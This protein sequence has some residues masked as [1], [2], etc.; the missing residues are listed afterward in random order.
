M[1][2]LE[3]EMEISAR[4]RERTTPVFDGTG[5]ESR[6]DAFVRTRVRQMAIALCILAALRILVFAAAFP[7]TNNTDEKLHFLT[8]R[9]YAQGQMPGKD[10]PPIDPEFARALLLYQSPEY[11]LSQEYLDRNGIVGPPYNLPPQAR[12]AVLANKFYSEKL[13]RWLHYGFNYE[14]QSAPFYYVVAGCWYRLGASL[15]F[16]DWGLAY[17]VRFLNPIA[18]ALVLWFSYC[19]VRRVYPERTFLQVAVPAIIAVF[20]QDVF[21]GMNRDVISPVL[22]AAALLCLIRAVDAKPSRYGFLLAGS[23]LAGLGFLSDIPNCVLFGALAATLWI[24]IERSTESRGRKVW[25]VSTSALAAGVLPCLWILRNYIVMGDLLGGKAKE[26]NLG[27][28]IKPFS[29]MVNHPLFS[30]VGSR[31]FLLQLTSRF[32]H[33]E[34]VWH[35]SPMKSAL[36]DRFYVVSSFVFVVVFLVDLVIRRKSIPT[37]QKLAGAQAL[38]LVITSVGF[39]ALIS[40]P[41][42][43]NYC[44]Y[45]SREYPYFVSGRIISGALLPFVL[46]YASGLELV[47]NLVRRWVSPFALRIMPYAL[48]SCLVVFITISEVHVRSGVFASPYNFFALWRR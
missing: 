48:L 21:F 30:F 14:A 9:M 43:F 12:D 28:T 34:Y 32:W 10:L 36:A 3:Q 42:D 16:R 38:F 8:I 35:N 27:W 19:F 46:M 23:L 44:A 15:G 13:T 17:W 22:A 47:T 11:G 25:V 33:G 2:S 40:L 4:P 18:Y 6:E 26:Q 29:D 45:P 39:L 24:F 1:A 37:L 31:E 20:P 7:L 5:V 41:F